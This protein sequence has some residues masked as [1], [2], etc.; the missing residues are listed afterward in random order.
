[1]TNKSSVQVPMVLENIVV[2]NPPAQFFLGLRVAQLDLNL[3]ILKLLTTF[4]NYV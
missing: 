1:M 3:T 2:W 4:L